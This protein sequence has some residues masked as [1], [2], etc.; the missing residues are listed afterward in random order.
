M[1]LW[2]TLERAVF[3]STLKIGNPYSCCESKCSMLQDDT[4]GITKRAYDWLSD[5]MYRKVGEPPVNVI[6]PVWTWYKLRGKTSKPDLRWVEFRHYKAPMVLIE[7]DVASKRVLL[8]DE[9]LWTCGQLNDQPCFGKRAD[10]VLDSELAWYYD[11]D[12]PKCVKE[13]Y[14]LYTWPRIFD[15][16]SGDYI[17]GTLWEILSND[18]ENVWYYNN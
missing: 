3:E 10:D 17:Q 5:M 14:K 1:K 15:V 16:D 2:T 7:L 11:M 12:A 6:Y 4:D 18:I 13:E 9:E 8:S